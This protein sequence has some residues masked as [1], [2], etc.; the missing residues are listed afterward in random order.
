MALKAEDVAKWNEVIKAIAPQV[1]L[2]IQAVMAAI[3]FF[4]RSTGEPEN[5]PKDLLLAQQVVDS[6][7]KAQA[8]FQQVVSTAK[9]ELKD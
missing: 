2:G 6:L 3:N 1:G 4:R 8:P 9:S 7:T 5:Q